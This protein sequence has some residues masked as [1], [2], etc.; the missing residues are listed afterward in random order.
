[1]VS[2]LGPDFMGLSRE[3]FSR[4]LAGRRA[5]IKSFLLNQKHVAGIGNV[6]VQ[7]PLFK[8]GIHP[9]QRMNTLSDHQ[10]DALWAALRETLQQSIDLG[11]S[12]WDLDLHGQRGMW[13]SSYF[14]VAYREGEPCPTCGTIVEKLK[15]GSTSSHICPACQP[16]AP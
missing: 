3:D 13:D 6:C 4:L 16:L 9:L 12:H 1:M 8:A 7:D 14:L 2:K 5:G 15:T 11:G 10:I